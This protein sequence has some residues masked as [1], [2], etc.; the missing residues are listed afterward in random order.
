MFYAYPDVFEIGI[1]SVYRLYIFLSM[2]VHHG[3]KVLVVYLCEIP[4]LDYWMFDFE[5]RLY[6]R[7]YKS[8]V[9]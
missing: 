3:N 8:A 4:N 2:S 9:L 5:N 6:T 7:K 1:C